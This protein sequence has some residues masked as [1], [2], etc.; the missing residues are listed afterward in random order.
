[1]TKAW[2]VL[3]GIGAFFGINTALHANREFTIHNN[4]QATISVKAV[5]EEDMGSEGNG[6]LWCD[7]HK[8]TASTPCVIGPYG[9]KKFTTTTKSGDTYLQYA[10]SLV[11]ESP[12][13]LCL[14]TQTTNYLYLPYAKMPFMCQATWESTVVSL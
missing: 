4:S 9:I 3:V 5:L 10:I 6:N 11:G 13:L 12:L 1:M 2:V 8:N 7:G 14:Y